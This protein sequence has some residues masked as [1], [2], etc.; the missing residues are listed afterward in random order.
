MESGETREGDV[1]FI[2]FFP[3]SLGANPETPGCFPQV[4]GS[5]VRQIHRINAATFPRRGGNAGPQRS[6]VLPAARLHLSLVR[7]P[8]FPLR[9]RNLLFPGN[10]VY[11]GATQML[12]CGGGSPWDPVLVPRSCCLQGGFLAPVPSFPSS[13]LLW[14]SRLLGQLLWEAPAVSSAPCRLFP[15]V[16]ILGLELVLTLFWRLVWIRLRSLPRRA[17]G[18]RRTLGTRRGWDPSAVR[19]LEKVSCLHAKHPQKF[20]SKL[21]PADCPLKHSQQSPGAS[22]PPAHAARCRFGCYGLLAGRG[23]G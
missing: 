18:P 16:R 13:P 8:R 17:A 7:S 12:P 20:P 2:C 9:R 19:S 10:S 21:L 11:F 5:S 22:L 14:E 3:P 4:Y 23:K 1:W 6:P 15:C